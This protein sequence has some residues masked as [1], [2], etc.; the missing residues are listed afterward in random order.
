MENFTKFTGTS[1]KQINFMLVKEL[2]ENKDIVINNYLSNPSR[3]EKF[4][5][6]ISS[7][8]ALPA[9]YLFQKQ[10]GVLIECETVLVDIYAA[11]NKLLEIEP[12]MK[13][14]LANESLTVCIARENSVK[15]TID[16][17]IEF[18]NSY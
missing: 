1:T 18:I 12:K 17:F 15:F 2:I 16:E 10:D 3:I 5:T 8:I 4:M 7:R 13:R 14:I 6:M 9:S 11:I